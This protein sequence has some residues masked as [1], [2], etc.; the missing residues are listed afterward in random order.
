M[1]KLLHELEILYVRE[2]TLTLKKEAEKTLI[3]R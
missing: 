3:K 2:L 1:T